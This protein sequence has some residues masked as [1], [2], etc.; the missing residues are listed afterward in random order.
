MT[1][2][3]QPIHIIL[4]DGI[5]NSLS[6]C[7]QAKVIRCFYCYMHAST[8]NRLRACGCGLRCVS[9]FTHFCIHFIRFLFCVDLGASVS[10]IIFVWVSIY[11]YCT[12][13]IIVYGCDTIKEYIVMYC[14]CCSTSDGLLV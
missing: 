9:L 8:I 6:L 12:V 11:L 2:P 14:V 10:Y 1:L 13:R 5:Y 3:A 7:L 4:Y